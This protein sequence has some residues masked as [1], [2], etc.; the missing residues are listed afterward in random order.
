MCYVVNIRDYVSPH[1]LTEEYGLAKV[2]EEYNNKYKTKHLGMGRSYSDKK[3]SKRAKSTPERVNS[4]FLNLSILR[5]K[6]ASVNVY[7]DSETGSSAP[8]SPT[9]EVQYRIQDEE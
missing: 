8:L 6:P 3:K 5:K 7:S 4:G 1:I 2:M 9:A